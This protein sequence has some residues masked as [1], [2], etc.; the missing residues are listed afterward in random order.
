MHKGIIKI[1]RKKS[2]ISD[3]GFSI[4]KQRLCCQVYPYIVW[5][6]K[7]NKK[8]NDTSCMSKFMKVHKVQSSGSREVA[9]TKDVYPASL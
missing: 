6:N 8:C 9:D 5:M 4:Y 2:I 1:L 3:M 7:L